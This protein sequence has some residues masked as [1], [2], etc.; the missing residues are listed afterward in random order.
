MHIA[1]PAHP[2]ARHLSNLSLLRISA[3]PLVVLGIAVEDELVHGYSVDIGEEGDM[4]ESETAAL[5][6]NRSGDGPEE[7]FREVLTGLFPPTSP[8]PLVKRLIIVPK[9]APKTRSP[10]S[11]PNTQG[12]SSR[13]VPRFGRDQGRP[14]ADLVYAP[15]E[16]VEG[17]LGKL[18]GEVVGDVLGE[19]GELVR[20]SRRN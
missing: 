1:Y 16:G 11:S 12:S 15:C 14:G 6:P 20:W 13:G 5:A 18:L 7:R 9:D 3:F 8:F 19:L 17:W 2:P 10:R 4:E